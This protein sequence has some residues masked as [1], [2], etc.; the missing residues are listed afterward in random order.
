MIIASLQNSDRYISIHPLFKELFAYIKQ[1]DWTSIPLGKIVL[2]GEDLYINH[3]DVQGAQKDLQPLEFHN[4]YIDVHV[5][6]SASETIGWADRVNLHDIETPYQTEQDCGFYKERP[7]QFFNVAVGM[8]AVVFP[9]DAHA[10]AIA[11]GHL[12]KLI[13][14]IKIETL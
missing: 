3:V 5:P 1:T 14:K 4:R 7:E 8:F 11:S 13:A 12:K 6:L 2:K 9:E 10:P